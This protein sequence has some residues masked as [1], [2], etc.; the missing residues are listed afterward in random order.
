MTTRRIALSSIVLVAACTLGLRGSP[1][2]HRALLSGD[3]LAHQARHTSARARVIVHGDDATLEAVAGRHHLQILRRLTGAAVLAANSAELAEL[4][5]DA[6]VDHLSGDLLVSNWMSVSNKSTAADQV[7]AGTSGLLGIG[8]VPG[9]TGQGIG[10]AVLD[11]GVSSHNALSNKV[12]ANVSFVTGDPA[13][14]DAFGHGT[15][16]AG[17]IAGTASAA[18]NVT[19]LYT[20]GI[21]PN[22]KIIN[23]RVLG[24]DGTGLVSDV[25]DGI[26]WVIN[27]RL[28]YNIRVINLSLGHPVFESAATDPLCVEVQ[29]AVNNGI[30]V[31]VA[32]GNK[33]KTP[34]GR[35]I[36]GGISSPGNSPA[37][38]TVGALNT[39]GTIS[40]SDDAVTTY[41]S[42]GPTR[43]DHAVKPD[44]AAPGNKI[45]SLEANNSVLP[46]LYSS[47][48]VAG[49]GDN[50]YMMLS[51]TSMAA[52]MVSGAVAL[53][54]QGTPS[55]SPAQVKLAMQTGATFVANGGLMGA[56][57]GSANFWAS[58]KNASSGLVSSLENTI[59]AG[60]GITP[61]GA[62]FWDKGTLSNRL[63][64]GDGYRL[65]SLLDLPKIW[66]NPALLR[67]GDLNLIGL[68]NPLARISSCPL[69]W[70]VVSTWTTENQINW[71]DTVYDPQGQSIMWGD[72]NTADDTSIM[73]GDS[74]ASPDPQ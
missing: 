51:G 5:A 48:Y 10:V 50:S 45:V 56:G 20:G 14:T 65:L 52:P 33:G 41:S 66:L 13:V 24:A 9:V 30:V 70:G 47:L 7:R 21:A 34:D 18:A 2:E 16:V 6:A 68:T 73:W 22:A 29:K 55:M 31:V 19:P 61:S 32:A 1:A 3:L 36:L 35:T 27:H 72:S 11:S 71:G 40:R 4:A 58:R 26:E 46:A 54:L 67:F 53:L 12:A 25:I 69:L 60:L 15:H 38:L 39:F 17:I 44:I 62:S 49:K 42:R 23:V 8:A 28:T 63:Y 74:M 57:A 43:F 64:E 37:A 59:V